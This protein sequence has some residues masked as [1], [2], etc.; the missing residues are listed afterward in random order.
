LYRQKILKE[1]CKEN[2]VHEYYF[3][4]NIKGEYFI[5]NTRN[6]SFYLKKNI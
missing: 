2:E 6:I 4:K 3:I 5:K 1:N